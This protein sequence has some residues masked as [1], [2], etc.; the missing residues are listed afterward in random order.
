MGKGVKRSGPGASKM[1]KRP[2]KGS[3][4]KRGSAS[5]LPTR[6]IPQNKKPGK[7]N[8]MRMRF[9]SHHF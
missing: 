9:Q 8:C 1:R 7:L 4:V 6:E 2:M 5:T 3:A